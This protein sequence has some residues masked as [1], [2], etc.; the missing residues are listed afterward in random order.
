MTHKCI[1]PSCAFHLPDAY[2]FPR[3]PWHMAP[4]RGPTKL[5]GA[6]AIAVAG[7]GGG[8]AYKKFREYLREKKLQQE[9]AE[10]RRKYSSPAE[11]P[12]QTAVTLTSG[13]RADTAQRLKEAGRKA[14]ATRRRRAVGKKAARTRIRR[15]T[16][17]KAAATRKER[18]RTTSH[19]SRQIGG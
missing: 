5:I 14:A 12:T 17:R 1:A 11:Q 15:A 10:W 18:A 16:A 3:C 13:R 6:I 7:L 4:G 8:I 19:I 2:P 9:R